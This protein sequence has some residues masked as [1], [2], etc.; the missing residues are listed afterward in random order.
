MMTDPSIAFESL[1]TVLRDCEPAAVAVSGG[2]DSMTL[3]HAAARV[4]GEA[5]SMYHAVSPAVPPAATERVKR[6]ALAG[7]W[8]LKVLSAGEFDDPFDRGD[9]F[10]VFPPL[11]RLK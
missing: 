8:H 4:L 10:D 9:G 11:L 5:V 7:A 3:A 2:V 1:A 6:H